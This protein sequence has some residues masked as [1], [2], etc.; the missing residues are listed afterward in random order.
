MYR[1]QGLKQLFEKICPGRVKQWEPLGPY[2]T[3]RIGGR[4]DW[5]IEPQKPSEI[6]QLLELVRLR[7][8]PWFVLGH[9][10]NLLVSDRGLRG[11]VIHIVSPGQ[12]IKSQALK[13][14]QVVLEVEAGAPLSKLV[15][16]GIRNGLQGLEFL[17]GIPGSVGGAWAM[18][19]GS[20]GK[21]IKDL[22]VF[23]NILAS[24]GRVIRKRKKQL[25]FGYRILKLEPGE[26]ILSGGLQVSRGNS[27]AIRQEAR[28]LWSQRRSTQP[29]GQPS[30]GSV[31]KN[32]PEAFAGQLI[33]KAGLKGVERGQARISEQHANFIVNQG[34]ARAKEVLYLM[35]LIRTRVRKQFGIL[36]EP[37]VRLWGCVLKEIA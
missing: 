25:F 34:G 20:Y 32:P 22:T 37:E 18:N 21:E 4:A 26:I 2:T 3:L 10:S 33:E 24:G 29:L 19:A 12:P 27:E 9:G 28:R 5:F 31:F 14:N 23:L 8:I 17:A 15:R 16:W 7:H 35:N 13:D 1:Q 30:C 6:K 11:L 36:L